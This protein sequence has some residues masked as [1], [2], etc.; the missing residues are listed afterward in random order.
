MLRDTILKDW[1]TMRDQT[2]GMW[3]LDKATMIEEFGAVRDK[4]ISTN[5]EQ[6][7]KIN[8]PYPSVPDVV[9]AMQQSEAEVFII[10]TKQRRFV[11]L[12]M[13][14]FGLEFP[15]DHLFTLEDPPK[16][17]VLR[18]LTQRPD[19]ADR[20]FHFVEDKLGT[21]KKVHADPD[22]Q[23]LKL[24]LAD[25]GYNTQKERMV[26]DYLDY[27]NLISL[28]DLTTIGTGERWVD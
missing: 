16:V 18:S 19:L 28:D 17:E 27:V 3:G 14:D 9:D 6:W 21:L 10:T 13:E 12:L 20:T 22:L 25:W 2:L 26:G 15:Q 11:N 8:Q 7:L 1:D 24:Y 23:D 4:W 5:K